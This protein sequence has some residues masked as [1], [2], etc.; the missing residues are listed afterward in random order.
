V[1]LEPSLTAHHGRPKLL[2][3]DDQPTNVR[4][5]HELFRSECDVFMA[6]S[7]EQAISVCRNQLPDLVLL[8]VVMDDIDGH[9]VCRRLKADPLT[10]DI[11]IIFITARGEEADE[12]FGLE[13]GAVDFISKPINPVIVRAR[14][15]THLTLKLQ[16][17]YLRSLAMLDG[18]TGIPNR[19][20]FESALIAAWAQA[21]RD[22]LPLSLVMI[23]VD[24]FKRY[25]DHYGHQ[26]GD[27]CLRRVAM[28]LSGSLNRPYDLVARYGGEEFICILPGADLDGAVK[29]AQRLQRAVAD[30]FIEH[31]ASDVAAHLT[32]SLGVASTIPVCAESPNL[33]VVAADERLYDAKQKGRAHIS[34]CFIPKA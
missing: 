31:A 10:V 30:L 27:T 29:I 26:E 24:F 34:S 33:L 21:C 19:R 7:G 8:D 4:V 32:I 18:L 6:N 25:N 17:D 5:L 16:G 22:S 9:E 1:Q 13:L 28:A 12:A 3:V 2:I 20:K 14:V 15:K 23:D 11:P